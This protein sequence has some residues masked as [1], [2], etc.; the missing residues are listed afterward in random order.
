MVALVGTAVLR[1][2]AREREACLGVYGSIVQ[3]GRVALG[4]PVVIES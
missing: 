2:I 4:D 3:P 1:T